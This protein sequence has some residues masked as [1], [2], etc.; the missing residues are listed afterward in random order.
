MTN[1]YKDENSIP[2]LIAALNTDGKTVV[3]IK[4]NPVNNA[5]KYVDASTGSDHGPT[6]DLRDENNV[7]CLMAVS[8]ADGKTPVVVYADTNG[9][10]LVKST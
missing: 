3:R 4:I 2:T 1:A 6:N 7:P 9:N 10:L 5:L 8:S